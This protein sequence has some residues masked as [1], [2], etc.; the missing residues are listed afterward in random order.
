MSPTASIRPKKFDVL[1]TVLKNLR[2]REGGRENNIK[3]KKYK[4]QTF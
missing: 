4:N 2:E 3:N 1:I